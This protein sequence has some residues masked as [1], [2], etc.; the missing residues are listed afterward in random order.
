MTLIDGRTQL[1]IGL[2][3]KLALDVQ[4]MTNFAKLPD[5]KKR[6]LISYIESSTTGEE[7]KNRVSEVVS[8][9]HK[10]TFS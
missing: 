8:N 2:G 1:P 4:A 5:E 10:G 9:L 7:A 3:M 6:E